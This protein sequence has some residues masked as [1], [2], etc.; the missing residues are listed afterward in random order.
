MGDIDG[1]SC[2]IALNHKSGI[3]VWKTTVGA[4][5]GSFAGPRS[6]PATDGQRVF[7]YNQFGDLLCANAQTG[8]PIWKLNLQKDLAARQQISKLDGKTSWG[9]AE[10]PFLFRDTIYMAPGGS[11]GAV[12][13]LDKR[14]GK[15]IWRCT[16][17]TEPGTYT[18]V[19]PIV[20]D[21]TPQ[22]L[23]VVDDSIAGVDV[24]TGKLLWRVDWPS[25]GSN[26]SDPV[27]WDHTVFMSAAYGVGAKGYRV[28]KSPDGTF[29]ARQIYEN[30]RIQN[31]NFG[32]I[33]DKGF[34]Y[35][36]NRSGEM[37]CLD[38]K[39]G[40]YKWS[41]KGFSGDGSALTWAEGLLIARAENGELRLFE[42]NPDRY[43]ERGRF[44]Q[45]DRT[46]VQT[47]TY[48]LV[49]DGKLYLRDQNKLFCYDLK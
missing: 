37:I 20:I 9:V 30:K 28:E 22:L 29:S 12:V 31:R 2:L 8:K 4:A 24:L 3:V 49:V 40:E 16:E 42:A 27:Y 35:T 46:D 25:V 17:L 26:C 47:W 14:T 23:V 11:Q 36:S 18:S 19:T 10:S 44:M 39:T 38:I 43:V 15:I 13:A 21:K 5:G 1:H 7:A 34:V 45:P 6:T 32:M 33:L 41:Q 48:P